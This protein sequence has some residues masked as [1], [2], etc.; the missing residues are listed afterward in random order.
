MPLPAQYH[1]AD[2]GPHHSNID[3]QLAYPLLGTTSLSQRS[4]SPSPARLLEMHDRETSGT[5][6]E[7]ISPHTDLN[8][9]L[10]YSTNFRWP[11]WAA[12]LS[13]FSSEAQPR[14]TIATN[15]MQTIVI[16]AQIIKYQFSQSKCQ[17]HTC[18]YI[19]SSKLFN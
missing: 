18:M 9:Y 2:A 1:E 10:F 14:Q 12:Q 19:I 11:S 7:K 17:S 8:P 15:T 4:R 16:A 5:I 13:R 3:N 6:K